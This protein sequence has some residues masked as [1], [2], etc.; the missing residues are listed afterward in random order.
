MSI[1][2]GSSSCGSGYGK[3]GAVGNAANAMVSVESAEEADHQNLDEE[4]EEEN[5]LG[6]AVTHLSQDIKCVHENEQ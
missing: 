5:E 4:E 1:Q 6:D 3:D 2:S